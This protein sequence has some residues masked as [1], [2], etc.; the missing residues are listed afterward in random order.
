[1]TPGSASSRS[2]RATPSAPAAR[3]NLGVVAERQ[4]DLPAAER[5]Y[6]EAHALAP[7]HAR[8][9][10]N[11][12]KVLRDQGKAA[13]SIPLFESALQR[14]GPLRRHRAPQRPRRRPP[15]RGPARAGRIRRPPRPRPL[16]GRLR[17]NRTLALCALDSGQPAPGGALRAHRPQARR[18]GRLGRLHPGPRLPEAGRTPARARRA[19]ARPGPGPGLRARAPEPRRHGPL[20]PRLRH[21]GEVLLPRPGAG[22]LVPG[23]APPPRLCAGRPARPGLEAWPGRGRRLRE[24]PG[25]QARRSRGHLRRRLRYAADRAGYDRALPFLQKCQ[26]LAGTP[27]ER[28]AAESKLRTIQA[29]LSAAGVEKDTPQPEE[30]QGNTGEDAGAGG[31]G[32]AEEGSGEEPQ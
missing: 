13:E 2:R 32:Q 17:R 14:P 28:Q 29:V 27:Q 3:Y 25:R 7:D 9:L 15:H 10:L 31:S 4:G 30:G 24:G 20:Q 11:L 26:E 18:Q 1:M 12:G 5:A 6:R 19:A 21:R 16:Q 8:T 23:R 22:A